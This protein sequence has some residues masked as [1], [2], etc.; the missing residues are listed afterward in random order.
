MGIPTIRFVVATREERE[1][2]FTST[3]TG[4]S[5][6]FYRFPFVELDLYAD[7][8]DGL[9]SVY[10]KSIEKAK[11]D[12]AILIFMHD[13]VYLSD[14]YWVD[15]LLNGLMSFEI[16]GVAGNRRR[17]ENQ[18]AWP[19]VDENFTWDERRYLSGVV[20]HGSGFPPADFCVFGPTCQ[21]VKLLDG[22]FLACRSE[23]L[24]ANDLRFDERFDFHFYDMDFCRSAEQKNVK[25]G[26]WSITLVHE[27]EGGFGSL[28]WN[29][30]REL[31][32]R[33]WAAS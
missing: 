4:R 5:L 31:Y 33:K 19:F 22:V 26:T 18:P 9:P 30:N 15:Q 23:V 8:K 1:R 6:N 10:N 27:S 12:P 11:F 3:A 2:F 14:F 21:E 16:V 17:S 20:A 7:N 29:K 25:M 28:G 24:H 13:D 32:F